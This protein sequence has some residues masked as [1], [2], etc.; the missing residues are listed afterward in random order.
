M[1]VQIPSFPMFVSSKTLK[2]EDLVEGFSPEV[3][4]AHEHTLHLCPGRAGHGSLDD[5]GSSE[6]EEPIT[7]RPIQLLLGD[8]GKTGH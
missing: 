7:I 1:G 4:W 6:L 2:R 3:A 8:C 5:N